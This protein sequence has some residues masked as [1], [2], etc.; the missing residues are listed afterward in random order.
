V[1]AGEPS[2]HDAGAVRHAYRIS[3]PAIVKNHAIIRNSVKVGCF[4]NSIA[5]EPQVV[6]ALLICNEEQDISHL[7]MIADR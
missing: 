1:G 4:N 6:C 5:H 3:Y 7:A 2:G